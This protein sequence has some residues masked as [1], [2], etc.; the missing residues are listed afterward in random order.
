[1]NPARKKACKAQVMASQFLG[2]ISTPDMSGI[3]VESNIASVVGTNC[4]S[5]VANMIHLVAMKR[6][7]VAVT[8]FV[9][10]RS[11]SFASVTVYSQIARAGSAVSAHVHSH[12]A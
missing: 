3:D 2:K 6:I 7:E 8:G 1:M 5:A 12:V 4:R 10:N 9:Q 11:T